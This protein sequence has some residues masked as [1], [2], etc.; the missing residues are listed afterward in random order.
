LS[1]D[2]N[3]LP[4]K[5]LVFGLPRT[6]T[7]VL[8]LHLSQIFGLES[9]SE[10]YIGDNIRT[11]KNIYKWTA[12]QTQCIIKL[13]T[14]NIISAT[15]INFNTLITSSGFDLIVIPVG[16]NLTNTCISLYYAEK[17]VKQYHYY[18]ND[19]I[20]QYPFH[21]DLNFITDNWKTEYQTFI[22]MLQYF[23]ANNINYATIDYNDYIQ[24]VKQTINGIEF[25]IEDCQSLTKNSL[26]HSNL[27]YTTLCQNYQEVDNLI[28]EITRIKC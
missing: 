21:M 11:I 4:N 16:K 27:D 5:I 18:K 3:K 1:K 19:K 2:Y 6:G 7:T 10:S 15:D 12:D 8:Q 9:L 13:L 24:N 17:V 25:S 23:D 14:T 26:V 20:L 22:K 28:N